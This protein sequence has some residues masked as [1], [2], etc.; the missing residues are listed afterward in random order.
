MAILGG[1]LGGGFN[2]GQGTA[3]QSGGWRWAAAAATAPAWAWG[4]AA[5]WRR[6]GGTRWAMAKEEPRAPQGD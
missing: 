1:L 4:R 2:S 3:G 5:V 6:A